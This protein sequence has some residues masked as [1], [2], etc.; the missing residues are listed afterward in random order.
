M[1]RLVG[2]IS[3]LTLAAL[4][5]LPS[6]A[7][8]DT[9]SIAYSIGGGPLITLVAGANGA[10]PIAGSIASGTW[11]FTYSASGSPLIPEPTLQSNTI[12]VNSKGAGTLTLYVTE[13]GLSTPT[14]IN[15]FISSFTTNTLS[16]GIASVDESTLIS[17]ADALYTGTTLSTVTVTSS[18]PTA[19]ITAA[20]P[21]LAAPY[22][23]TEKYVI[24]TTGA[25]NTNDTIDI[26][27]APK[28]VPEP[29][30]LGLLSSGL[31]GIGL[32]GLRRRKVAA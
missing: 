19:N 5:G 27:A 9:I 13:Q 29:S 21:F 25:G 16:S 18:G 31:F 28:A 15:E 3:I 22:S 11:N 4:V 30:S 24:S 8:A 2:G 10:F 14:G 6:L 20:T 32:L 1:K 12:N 7:R 26:A 17:L 23:E